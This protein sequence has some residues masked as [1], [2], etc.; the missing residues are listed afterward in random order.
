MGNEKTLLKRNNFRA[1]ITAKAKVTLIDRDEFKEITSSD[2]VKKIDFSLS[3]GEPKNDLLLSLLTDFLVQID[4]KLDLVLNKLEGKNTGSAKNDLEV[5][6][7]VDISGS[8][9][10]LVLNESVDIGQILRIMIKLPGF[11]FGR[12]EAYGEVVRILPI[13]END[14]T[15]YNA[16]IKFLNL[17]EEEKERLISYTFS[18]H[19][20]HIRASTD[21]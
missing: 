10:S 7:T 9:V 12:F 5:R 6:Q 8:G 17:K 2:L 15:T 14:Q 1:L 3:T 13:D 20:K 16:G 21:Y 19:R 11:P 18:Q 4:E